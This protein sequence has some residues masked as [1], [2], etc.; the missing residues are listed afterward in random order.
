M[1]GGGGIKLNATQLTGNS[2]LNERERLGEAEERR[3]RRRWMR[4]REKEADE[5]KR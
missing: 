5:A 4:R 2:R 1:G 3:E